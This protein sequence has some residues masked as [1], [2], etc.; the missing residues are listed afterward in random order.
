MTVKNIP[1]E[2][3]LKLTCID[4]RGIKTY[5]PHTDNLLWDF[6]LAGRSG[7]VE[8]IYKQVNY[9]ADLNINDAIDICNSSAVENSHVLPDDFEISGSDHS[10]I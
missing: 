6:D 8:Y 7:C 4:S 10:P 1:N 5:F 3:L 2:R 9:K